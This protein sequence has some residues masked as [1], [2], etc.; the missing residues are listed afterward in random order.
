LLELYHRRDLWPG[1]IVGVNFGDRLRLSGY[2]WA[3]AE[4]PPGKELQVEMRWQSMQAM[5]SDFFATL[6]LCDEAG[7]LWGLGSKRLNDIDAE[8]YWDERGLEQAVL[9]PT[10]R[11]PVAET[12]VQAF[13]LPVDP[14]TPP[15]YY[16][17][18][19]RVHPAA[20]WN[21]LPILGDNKASSGFDYALGK[22]RVLPAP[23]APSVESLE[24][25]RL[26]RADF[27][28]DL[29]L[30]GW[31]ISTTDAR[32]GDRLGL[33]LF[34]EAMRPME[35]DY[36]ARLW[37]IDQIGQFGGEVY[38]APAG[39]QYPT[40]QW[41]SGEILRA[42]HDLTVDAAT[43]AGTYYLMLN[44]LDESGG[45]LRMDDLRLGTIIISGRQRLFELPAP[46][47]HPV[48][49]EFGGLVRLLGYDLPET[50]VSPGDDLILT[51]YWQGVRRMDTSYTVFTHLLDEGNRIW[52]QQDSIPVQGS[53]P[54]TGWLPEEVIVDRY[55]IPVRTD[56]PAGPHRIEVGLYDAATGL[57]L[58]AVES[59]EQAL[60]GDHL[61]L[62]E[63]LLVMQIP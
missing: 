12:T 26:R 59:R 58:P 9:I 3:Y 55:Q 19:L 35:T 43:P 53:Y 17:V 33:S 57:R 5:D 37:L 11:W 10:S 45:N 7:H 15:G 1:E 22:A 41:R 27:G 23:T 29:R 38:A 51:L 42:Q 25:A 56:A 36:V 32:P 62:P 61:L 52:G 13:E 63:L 16:T 60:L 21:G 6:T 31:D 4:A 46:V 14:A 48:R 30:L 49:V 50:R 28:S 39:A 8:T 2:R 34:W 40:R 44:V 47:Q 18:L 20:V 24:I 54:T